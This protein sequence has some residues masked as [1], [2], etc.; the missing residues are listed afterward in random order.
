MIPD[1]KVFTQGITTISDDELNTLVQ[2]CTTA[3]ALRQFTGLS[4]MAVTLLGLNALNDGGGGVFYWKNGTF[5]DDDYSVIVPL[6]TATGAWLRASLQTTAYGIDFS[7]VA[8]SASPLASQVIGLAVVTAPVTFPA[9]FAGAKGN[10]Q[11]LP[12]ASFVANIYQTGNVSPIGTMT[13]ATN[14]SFTFSTSGLPIV[15]ASGDAIEFRAPS[16]PDA[17]ANNFA[18][19]II[20]A[21]AP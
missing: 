17:T 9:N 1:N 3:A 16:V 18:W 5:T 20:A 2:G 7:Y 14:G 6:G 15:L 4:N 21:S 12:T 8:E 19:R 11:N 10:I 13:I